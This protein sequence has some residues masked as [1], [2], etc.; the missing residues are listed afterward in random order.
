MKTAK[1]V[2]IEQVSEVL[3]DKNGRAYKKITL[4][5]PDEIRMYN[6]DTGEIVKVVGNRKT[7]VVTS[8]EKTYL[9]DEPDMLWNKDVGTNLLGDVVTMPVAEEYKIDENTV[10]KYTCFVNGDS[11]DAVLWFQAI[12]KAFRNNGHPVIG[13]E[14]E[15][16]ETAVEEKPTKK[17]APRKPKAPAVE[18]KETPEPE[19]EP[20]S[21]TPEETP[22]PELSLEATPPSADEVDLTQQQLADALSTVPPV[23]STSVAESAPDVPKF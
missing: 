14:V 19:P 5:T 20:S 3:A 9:N 10:N 6:E 1:T 18:Q 16:D 13:D 2:V 12:K 8:Y 11:S 23:E 15:G 22:T 21:E 17:R 7:A 4:A